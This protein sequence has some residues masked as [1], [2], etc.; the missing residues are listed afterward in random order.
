MENF[1]VPKTV[2]D[3]VSAYDNRAKRQ[4]TYDEKDIREASDYARVHSVPKAAQFALY[5]I[6]T[7]SSRTAAP[8]TRPPVRAAGRRWRRG[9]FSQYRCRNIGRDCKDEKGT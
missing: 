9:I 4:K 5:R 8:R 1:A 6:G 3:A 2:L 7:S